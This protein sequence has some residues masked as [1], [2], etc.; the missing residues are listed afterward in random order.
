MGVLAYSNAERYTPIRFPP[1]G[2]KIGRTITSTVGARPHADTFPPIYAWPCTRSAI[3]ESIRNHS[4]KVLESF[5]SW[6]DSDLNEKGAERLSIGD[7]DRMAFNQE[8]KKRA[9]SGNECR[10]ANTPIRFPSCAER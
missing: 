7:Q 3:R 5:A 9:R 6:G 1:P 4:E 10:Y 8:F 2:E